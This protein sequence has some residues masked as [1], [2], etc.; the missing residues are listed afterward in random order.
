MQCGAFDSTLASR[1]ISRADAFASIEMALE[2]SRSASRDRERGQ[3]NMFGLFDA[4]P[5]NSGGSVIASAG[6]Y[7]KAEAWDRREMLVRERQ[8]LGFYVSGHPLERYLKGAGSLGKLDAVPT[9]SLANAN[10]WAVVRICGMVEGYRERIFKDG[11]GKIAFFDLEDLTGRV[12]CKVRGNQIDTY[13]AVLTAGEPV[14]ITG[15]VSF[16]FRDADGE[17]EEEG[18]R[19]PTIFV[20]E[21]V[22]L[23][24]AVKSD[25]KQVAIRL[26]AER[27]GEVQL[28]KMA[29]VLARSAGHCPVTLVLALKDGA[30]A[31]LALGKAYRVEVSDEVLSGL[32][33]VFGEQ[34]A[35]LR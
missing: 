22:R 33:R 14:L 6:D 4:G 32:E 27:T 30:E 12:T 34:V 5:K 20:N 13:A 17:E 21:A 29:D 26:R 19:E 31:V 28:R 35:E 15:K 11:G 8:S 10:D 3:T 16:P 9:S 24:D 18:P 23:A 7:A 2:R 1:G 25:T